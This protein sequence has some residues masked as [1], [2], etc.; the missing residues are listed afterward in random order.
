MRYYD[1]KVERVLAQNEKDNNNYTVVSDLESGDKEKLL[2]ILNPKV[3][4]AIKNL[5]ALY[6]EDAC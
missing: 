1:K 3:V 4:N 6:T 2:T 5:Q